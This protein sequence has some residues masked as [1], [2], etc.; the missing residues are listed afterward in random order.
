MC[1]QIQLFNYLAKLYM[2]I[3]NGKWKMENGKWKMENVPTPQRHSMPV[4]MATV[5]WN[6]PR[7]ATG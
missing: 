5:A 3:E 7:L 2:R 4:A 1:T 6:L